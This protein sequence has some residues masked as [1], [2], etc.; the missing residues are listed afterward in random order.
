MISKIKVSLL[1]LLNAS[2]MA[3]AQLKLPA[4]SPGAKIMQ[5]VGLTQ[6]EIS[7]SRPSVKDR[8][9]FGNKGLVPYDTF[10]RTGANSATKISFDQAVKISGV[11][12]ARG[13][14]AI[15]TKPGKNNWT[16]F[17]Y[18]Y[19]ESN[20]ESYV[21][22]EPLVTVQAKSTQSSE[23][24]ESFEIRIQDITFDSVHIILAWDT[25]KVSLPIQLNTQKQ[26]LANIDRAFNVP[27]DF[28]YFQ[29]AVYLH[30][31]KLD[32][33]KALL[34]IQKITKK[35]KALFFQVYREAIILA[36]LQRKGEA[37]GAA[38]RSLQLSKE[39]KNTDFIRLNTNLIKELSN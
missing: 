10:W 1:I 22:K 8:D 26:S 37:L 24:V 6:I 3:S 2:I 15:L 14:Y 25:T 9:V 27:S 18:P 11:D 35:D 36:D 12:L 33:E 32:L 21:S 16:I 4:L 28:D 29:A 34:Y 23:K 19:K 20:W 31:S 17:F 30:E 7:Y 5:A 38:K 13:E 39:A